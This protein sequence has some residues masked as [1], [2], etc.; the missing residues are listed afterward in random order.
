MEPSA[1]TAAH[2]DSR[3]RKFNIIV[4][5]VSLINIFNIYTIVGT[6]GI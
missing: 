4:L 6:L 3:L 2:C 1:Q 5:K